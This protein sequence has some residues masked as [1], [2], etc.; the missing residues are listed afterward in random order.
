MFRKKKWI[1]RDEN[2]KFKRN[3]DD[4][5][6]ETRIILQQIELKQEEKISLNVINDLKKKT[7]IS[8]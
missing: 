4:I 5:I 1:V 3:I 7:I 2:G 6:D 8:I